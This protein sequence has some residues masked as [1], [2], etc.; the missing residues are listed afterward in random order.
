MAA[1]WAFVDEPAARRLIVPVPLLAVLLPLVT[2]ARLLQLDA[3]LGT[4]AFWMTRPIDR[5]RVLTAKLIVAFGAVLGPCLLLSV[6]PLG[7]RG[8]DLRPQHY[9]LAFAAMLVRYLA[10]LWLPLVAAGLA[11]GLGQATLL[12]A[13]LAVGVSAGLQVVA[14]GEPLGGDY[15]PSFNAV[16]AGLLALQAVAYLHV[17]YRTRRVGPALATL[18][19]SGA[20][21]VSLGQNWRWDF[22]AP[23]RTPRVSHPAGERTDWP[24]TVEVL[25]ERGLQ[26]STA[27]HHMI[28]VT[29][30]VRLEGLGE[31]M[32]LT[33]L[34][35]DTSAT[36]TS[37][38]TLSHRVEKRKRVDV[39]FGGTMP[40]LPTAV[41]G[42]PRR[43]AP[44]VYSVP[45]F[46]A[47][48]ATPHG[49]PRN[50]AALRGR[51][52]FAV[53]RAWAAERANARHGRLGFDGGRIVAASGR[54]GDDA[55]R[56]RFERLRLNPFPSP[57]VPR[58]TEHVVFDPE[59]GDCLP[60]SHSGGGA[61]FV[62]MSL[63]SQEHVYG[64]G[65]S[66]ASDATEMVLLDHQVLGTLEV[67]FE[68][69]APS[70]AKPPA[71]R[72]AP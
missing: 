65:S 32:A 47:T 60:F 10:L 59:R 63:E 14:D 69:S 67:P 51:L 28:S 57:L 43:D 45:V 52:R 12:A 68:Y 25:A 40:P 64:L 6:V 37:G 41:L 22:M 49:D 30:T 13:L 5:T 18:A 23:L 2:I 38:A 44:T 39:G 33:P 3:A 9:V 56:L 34:G 26:W 7:L 17:L 21:I 15:A 31:G 24:I 16:V 19:I 58:W 1:A 11:R 29:A 42:C 46:G 71:Q 20:A 55:L 8:L 4:T 61:V 70:T 27:P 48:D 35:Y 72:A 62:A 53:V 66:A 50:I 36:L 54:E